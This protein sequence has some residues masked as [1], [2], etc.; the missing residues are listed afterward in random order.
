M[1]DLLLSN[2]LATVVTGSCQQ[3]G[4]KLGGMRQCPHCSELIQDAAVHCRFCRQDVAPTIASSEKWTQF[5]KAFHRLSAPRQQAAWDKLAPVDQAYV[6][7]ALG[8][9]PPSLPGIREALTDLKEGKKARKSH[10]LSGFV[11]FAGFCLLIIVSA[12]FLFPVIESRV[13]SSGD[14]PAGFLS[15]RER[16]DEAINGAVETVTALLADFDGVATGAVSSTA[17]EVASD[18]Q[19]A[20]SQLPVDAPP[21]P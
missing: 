19:P 6:Q 21:N 11:V 4:L 7:K 8:I 20:G 15:T 9:V 5:G 1:I 12:Y 14:G 18:A 13:S 17:L 3:S 10:S 16:I 2:N